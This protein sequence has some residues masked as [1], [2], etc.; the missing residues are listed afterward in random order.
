MSWELRDY[1]QEAK[2]RVS[3][4]LGNGSRS[5]LLVM[6]TGTGKTQTFLSVADEWPQGDVLVLAHRQE[7][8]WQ[9]FERWKDLTGEHGEIE[10][11]DFRR[12][13]FSTGRSRITFASKDSLFRRAR[14]RR[15]FPDPRSVGL[16]IIDEAHHAIKRNKTYQAILDYFDHPDL[17]ILGVTATPDRADEVALGQTF[18]TVAYDYP[19]LSPSGGPSAIGDGWLVP[20]RQEYV[21]VDGL[22]FANV[23]SR[24]GDFTDSSL[25]RELTK[26]SILHRLTAPTMDIAGDKLSVVFAAGV[27]Q[28]SR[29]AEIFNRRRDGNAFCLVSRVDKEDDHDF[30]VSAQDK[31]KRSRLLKRFSQKDFQYLCNVGCLTE[32]YDNPS[33][34]MIIMGRMTRSRSLYC[35]QVGR[36]T[37]PL[38]GVVDGLSSPDER[39]AAIATSAKPY[40]HVLDFVGNS[41]H[42]LVSSLDILGG[43]YPDEVIQEAK[44]KV[45]KAGHDIDEDA[46][47]ILKQS[48]IDVAKRIERRKKIRASASYRRRDVDPFNVIGVVATREPGWHQGRQ[49]TEKQ[50]EAL[51]K[52]GVEPHTIDRMSFWE[53]SKMMDNLVQRSHKKMATYKQCKL[54]KRFNVVTDS[55][56]FARAGQLITR[57]KRN[58]WKYL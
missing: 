28:A 8:V 32:G 17:R 53:A 42:P 30:V 20:I 50:V 54:L 49:P 38:T 19:L 44:K 46:S 21:V 13:T 58:G 56:T 4:A 12:S 40:I 26:E 16:V 48:A 57:L 34:Q 14:L 51:G 23:Q 3:D 5:T 24:G 43:Q 37:R 11:A 10:M 41:R 18:D 2:S 29:M 47:E 9:P 31:M 27:K 7:L 33:L 35:Q 45:E 52:F 39:K 22:D 55:L 1:Q 15:A 25:E 36:G 6:P